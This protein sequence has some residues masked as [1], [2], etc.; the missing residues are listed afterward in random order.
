MHPVNGNLLEMGMM[1]A[2]LFSGLQENGVNFSEDYTK[3][4]KSTMVQKLCSVMGVVPIDPD[5]SYVLTMD[6]VIKILAIHMRFRYI[7]YH[8]FNTCLAFRVAVGLVQKVNRRTR[9]SYDKLF[10]HTGAI[11]LLCSWEKLVVER[12]G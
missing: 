8:I 4:G 9:Y 2:D 1:S 6:N 5:D 11:F 12:P 7:H 10:E 3:W